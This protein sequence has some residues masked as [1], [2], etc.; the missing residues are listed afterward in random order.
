[1]THEPA[2]FE[3]VVAPA[4]VKA[5]AAT[6]VHVKPVADVSVIVAVYTVP[7]TKGVSAGAHTTA[8]VHWRSAVGAAT[9]TPPAAGTVTPETVR[10]VIATGACAREAAA[11]AARSCGAALWE[12]DTPQIQC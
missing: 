11:R 3:T 1:M 2:V 12:A 4:T 5:L 7:A 9:G 10:S 6:P 8:P